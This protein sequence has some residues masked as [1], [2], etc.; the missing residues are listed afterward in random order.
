V[1]R[2]VVRRLSFSLIV[3]LAGSALIYG[4]LDLAGG[5][6]IATLT[7]GRPVDDQTKARIV[8]EYHLDDPFP[9]RYFAWMKSAVRGDFGESY[10]LKENVSTLVASRVG[11]TLLL[12]AMSCL[13]IVTGGLLVGTVA[14]LSR[15]WLGTALPAAAAVG[16]GVPTFVA[17]MLLLAVFAVQLG[18]FPV[19]SS[20]SGFFDRLWHLTLPAIAL[21]FA[22]ISYIGRITQVSVKNE[23]GREHVVTAVARGL[24]RRLIIRR[25][26]LR[27]AAIPVATVTGLTIA[28]LVIAAVVV[29]RSFELNG[30]GSLLVSSIARSDFPTVQ[31]IALIVIVL[32]IVVNFVVDLLVAR[33]DPRIGLR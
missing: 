30:I 25:H 5:N 4:S 26:V 12:V 2:F 11:T 3:L 29:E 32:Y 27:N 8:A 21:A 19:Y 24:P 33:L 6:P 17:A 9:V 1:L 20:G 13:L 10:V 23:L 14:G 28:Y 22:Q 16:L 15:G 18:W 7:A 31:A